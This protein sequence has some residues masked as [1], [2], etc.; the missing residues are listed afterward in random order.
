MGFTVPASVDNPEGWGPPADCVPEEYADVPYSPFSKSDKLGRAADWTQTGFGKFG[1]CAF[2]VRN[3][4][5]AA[6]V[7]AASQQ[8]LRAC[9]RRIA[10][11]RTRSLAAEK[12]LGFARVQH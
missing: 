11:A 1:G 12:G 5:S 4:H 10:C 9:L 2:F 3:E 6:A 7:A 8:R